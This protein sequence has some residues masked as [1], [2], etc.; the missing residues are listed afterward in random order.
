MKTAFLNGE[1]SEDVY[2]AQP[3]G[4]EKA[5]QE[6]MVYKLP[7]ASYE[8]HQP[9]CAWHA[10][11]YSCLEGLDFTQCPYEH[12]VYTRKEGGESFI[13][14]M[15]VDDLHVTGFKTTLIELF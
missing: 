1:I 7:K 10:K 12:A 15:Y 14:M 6:H 5:G 11:L 13:I 3:E 2:V 4:F 8:L 9:P